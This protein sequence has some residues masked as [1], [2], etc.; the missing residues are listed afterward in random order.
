MVWTHQLWSTE[1]KKPKRNIGIKRPSIPTKEKPKTDNNKTSNNDS[2]TTG[3][4]PKPNKPRS[5]I[6]GPFADDDDN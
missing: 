3:S 1:P 4:N 5:S 2:G 6:L